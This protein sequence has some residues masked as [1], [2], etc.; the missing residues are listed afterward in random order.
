MLTPDQLADLATTAA[1]GA[2]VLEIDRR[3]FVAVAAHLRERGSAPPD[4]PAAL[5]AAAKRLEEAAD[6]PTVFV[7]RAHFLALLEAAQAA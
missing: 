1:A 3:T 7:E 5:L 6:I 4:P 2:S